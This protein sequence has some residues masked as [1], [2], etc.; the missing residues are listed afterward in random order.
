MG[1]FYFIEINDIG[2]VDASNA[3]TRAAIVTLRKWL[4]M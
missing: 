1:T 3:R 4:I 2:V